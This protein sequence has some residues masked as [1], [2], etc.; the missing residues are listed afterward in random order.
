MTR[1]YVLIVSFQFQTLLMFWRWWY[2]LMRRWTY[3]R[4]GRRVSKIN[5]KWILL[6]FWW[7]SRPLITNHKIIFLLTAILA[8]EIITLIKVCTVKSCNHRQKSYYAFILYLVDAKT[9]FERFQNSCPKNRPQV[10]PMGGPQSLL[11]AD[12]FAS[13]NDIP[14]DSSFT[15]SIVFWPRYVDNV[16]RFYGGSDDDLQSFFN[17]L[18]AYYPS[19]DFTLELGEDTMNFFDLTIRL[20]EVDSYQTIEI[21]ISR[22]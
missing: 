18:N 19:M 2:Q 4:L 22:I 13:Q 10:I 15:S 8:I 1:Y 14:K 5:L 16:L 12:V 7:E 6:L 21:S 9:V 17:K 20:K 11:T 3:Q